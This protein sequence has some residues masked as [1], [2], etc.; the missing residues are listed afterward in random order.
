MS[1]SSP[2]GCACGAPRPEG[3]ASLGA[4]D[5]LCLGAT[6]TF[7]IMALLTAGFGGAQADLLCLTSPDAFALG[8][9]APMYVLMG[10]FHAAPW[11][12]VLSGGHPSG[13]RGP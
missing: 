8:G 10:V 12:R 5:W 2:G 3:V 1:A 11:L 6:P 7:A 4:A 9:M 13:R